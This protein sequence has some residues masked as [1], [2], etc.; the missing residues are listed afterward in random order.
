MGGFFVSRVKR[1]TMDIY[2][3]GD[4]SGVFDQQ[5]N[6]IYVF[7]GLIF[8]DK[9]QKDIVNRRYH[10][11][12]KKIAPKYTAGE[13]VT[14]GQA[15]ELKACFIQNKHRDSLFRVTNG[16]I[17]YVFVIDQRKVNEGVFLNKKSKQRYLDWVYKVGLKRCFGRLIESGT[18][19]PNV[20][21]NPI[22][23]FDEHNTATD[24][25]YE[26]REAIEQEFKIGTV[27]FKWNAFH[28]P[29]SPNMKGSVSL[30][31]RDSKNAA[32]VRAS[33]VIANRGW[34]AYVNNRQDLIDG[35]AIVIRFP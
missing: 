33:D 3:Y 2:V 28:P 30:E 10:A 32:L 13:D 20:V 8:L 25:R 34:R 7:G 19:N 6:E 21:D 17:R 12:E 31:F 22:I 14:C 23:Q 11:L 18:L 16:C 29:I 1:R 35:K 9:R 15:Q 5:H 24:G 26:L 4:E 27:N